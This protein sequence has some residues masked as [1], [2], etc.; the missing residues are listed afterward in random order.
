MFLSKFLSSKV[1]SLGTLGISNRAKIKSIE[2]PAN[3][4]LI[5]GTNASGT[6]LLLPLR[7]S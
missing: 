7:S 4:I 3:S 5:I 1:K 2:I 6:G